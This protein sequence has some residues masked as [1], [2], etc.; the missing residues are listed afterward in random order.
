LGNGGRELGSGGF[1][2]IKNGIGLVENA[3]NS[4]LDGLSQILPN[5]ANV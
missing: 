1:F 3:E 2:G 5:F 4:W